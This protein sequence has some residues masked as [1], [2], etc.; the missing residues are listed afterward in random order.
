VS[1]R[2]VATVAVDVADL[3]ALHQT[4]RALNDLVHA[5][6]ADV[7][8]HAAIMAARGLSCSMLRRLGEVSAGPVLHSRTL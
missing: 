1:E 3:C 4:M 6:P 7:D 5:P 8:A 2:G